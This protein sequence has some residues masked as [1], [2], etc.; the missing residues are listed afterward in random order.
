MRCGLPAC[1][2]TMVALAGEAGQAEQ[3]Q[4]EWLPGAWPIPQESTKGQQSEDSAPV[5]SSR[6]HGPAIN[7]TVVAT[8]KAMPVRTRI[9]SQ[10]HFIT[11]E[12]PHYS[13][14][15]RLQ[16]SRIWQ[17]CL[18]RVRPDFRA[19]ANRP[20]RRA[21]VAQ[22]GLCSAAATT[23]LWIAHKPVAGNQ[24]GVAVVAIHI[25]CPA[26]TFG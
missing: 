3:E 16:A 15:A 7:A 18:D 1:R 21:M 10:G 2:K 19:L 26:E 14:L 5:P 9:F 23:P 17:S 20:P 12:S 13:E 25:A 22:C 8:T 24:S 4:P 11:I 6:W